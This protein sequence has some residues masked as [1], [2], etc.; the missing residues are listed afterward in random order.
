VLA[1]NPPEAA[2]NAAALRAYAGQVGAALSPTDGQSLFQI[3]GAVV[4]QYLRWRLR[5]ELGF[6]SSVGV[7]VNAILAKL[8]SARHKPVQ[9]TLVPQRSP[10]AL[11]E[12][13]PASKLRGFGGKVGRAI[14]AVAVQGMRSARLLRGSGGGDG[15]SGDGVGGFRG[16]FG[17]FRGPTGGGW[18][19]GGHCGAA[20]ALA[21][22][23]TLTARAM[24][25][26]QTR[27]SRGRSGT[28]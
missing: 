6:T 24:R 15:G 16:S 14:T 21:R 26:R 2:A 7:S 27:R 25:R 23:A 20:A 13:L 12:I 9:Q 22:R 1:Y 5:Q 17:S 3:G 11:I 28:K 8:G 4:A 18:A 10:A 19:G